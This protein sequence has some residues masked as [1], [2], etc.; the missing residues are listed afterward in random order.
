[1]PRIV[2]EI[3]KVEHVNLS[4]EQVADLLEKYFRDG[5]DRFIEDNIVFRDDGSENHHNGDWDADP[6]LETDPFYIN[7]ARVIHKL[8]GRE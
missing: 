6:H 3:T 2:V 8:R 1:M 5:K 4:D 7:L